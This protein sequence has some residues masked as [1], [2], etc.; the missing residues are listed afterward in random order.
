[1][2][3]AVEQLVQLRFPDVDQLTAAEMCRELG[4][5][6]GRRVA[7]YRQSR[8]LRRRNSLQQPPPPIRLARP[9]QRRHGSLFS[10]AGSSFNRHPWLD[11]RG[12]GTHQ[13]A[14]DSHLAAITDADAAEEASKTW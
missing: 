6:I 12:A 1:M 11:L 13:S 10:L 9:Q 3:G 5:S 2:D 14:I 7:G 8:S 4:G